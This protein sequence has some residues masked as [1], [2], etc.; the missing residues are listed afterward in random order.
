MT[1]IFL[2]AFFPVYVSREHFSGKILGNITYVQL[3]ERKKEK[4]T[5]ISV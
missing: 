1:H 5:N 4:Y 3:K 2:L